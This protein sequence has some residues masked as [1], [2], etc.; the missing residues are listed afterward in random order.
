[1]PARRRHRGPVPLVHP[2]PARLAPPPRSPAGSA[3]TSASAPARAVRVLRRHQPARLP[4]HHHLGDAAHPRSPP[5]APRLHGLQHHQR[6][7]FVGRGHHQGR[8]R[9]RAAPAPARA[10]QLPEEG[11]RRTQPQ[12]RRLAL[13]RR[14]G[15]RRRRR[16]AGRPGDRARAASRSA[17]SSTST[18]LR[19]RRRP[20]KRR[21]PGL[22]AA[23]RLSRGG[24]D[25]QPARDVGDHPHLA[26]PGS[27]GGSR[28]PWPRW[29][30]GPGRRR[31]PSAG[32]S[33]ICSGA[34]SQR[35]RQLDA[36]RPAQ[37]PPAADERPHRPPLLDVA[38][39][40][41]GD[42][43]GPRLE[44]RRDAPPP[45]GPPA[46]RPTRAPAPRGA[47]SG[48]APARPPARRAAETAPSGPRPRRAAAQHL[49][50]VPML[51]Q[52]GR[53]L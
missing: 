40:E 1:M 37:H 41:Q 21:Y 3:R 47:G 24:R 50:L 17:S 32:P 8:A 23:W 43:E 26:R 28:R 27:R 2:P 11:D 36:P 16:S 33:R 34:L 49:H 51:P 38:H 19:M 52:A 14:P 15:A 30:P 53:Q 12:L 35:K 13:Q 5:P 29:A 45:A 44:Q 6:H 4:V 7:P 46:R 39:L 9:P 48:G 20:T 25:R 18:P 22:V 31:G 42:E 10:S